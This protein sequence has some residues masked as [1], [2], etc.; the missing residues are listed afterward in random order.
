[1]T[2]KKYN[3][4]AFLIHMSMQQLPSQ[5]PTYIEKKHYHISKKLLMLPTWVFYGTQ[6]LYF[7]PMKFWLDHLSLVQNTAKLNY[8]QDYRQET[9]AL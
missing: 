4:A 7:N 2:I 1:M 9:N 5:M 3:M 6:I 8:F